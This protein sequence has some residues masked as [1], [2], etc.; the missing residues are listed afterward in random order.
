FHMWTPDVYEGAPTPV[1]AFLSIGSKAGGFVIALRLLFVVFG[2]SAPDW[3][4][5][6]TALAILSMIMGNLI[7]LA[8]TSF[9]RMLAYSSIA[10]V[11]YILIGL[12]SGTQQ[13]LAAM[14][15]YIIV[16]GFMNLGAFAG[17]ILF[18]NEA[19]SDNIDDFAGLIKKRPYLAL[20]MSVCLLNLAGLPIPPAG[21]FAKLFIFGAGIQMPLLI[22]TI[23]IGWVLVA[24]A[25]A[26]SIPAVYYYSRVVIKMIVADPSPKVL[27]MGE[28]RPF[29]D[30][31]QSMVFLALWLC[32]GVIFL[33]G[34]VVVDPVMSISRDA[35]APLLATPDT[36]SPLGMLPNAAVH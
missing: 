13:G 33:T 17:A 18:A 29:F 32:I 28:S 2:K 31:P 10:H 15:F 36:K 14:M 30:S 12:V 22:G 7:A 27:A 3:T 1:T 34:T 11:G 16:Y 20:L 8:Q 26:T 6:I 35:V 19:G 21:F 25:L 9:K 4:V 24:V 5:I 23:P